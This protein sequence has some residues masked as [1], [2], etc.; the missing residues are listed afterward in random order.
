MARVEQRTPRRSEK[1]G[2]NRP[3]GRARGGQLREGPTARPQPAR[4]SSWRSRSSQIRRSIRPSPRTSLPTTSS[5]P[6]SRRWSQSSQAARNS[7]HVLPAGA[8]CQRG[9][10]PLISPRCAAAS[11][12]STTVR[13]RCR[14]PRLPIAATRRQSPP[15]GHVYPLRGT[16][17]DRMPG[18]S[19]GGAR[20]GSTAGRG[21]PSKRDPDSV[22]SLTSGSVLCEAP[23]MHAVLWS[24]AQA[25]A[26]APRAKEQ[27]THGARTCRQ[28]ILGAAW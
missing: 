6:R 13:P 16:S 4:R 24:L 28:W 2:A 3:G 12:D 14:L 27:V 8:G 11:A 18:G 5:G 20:P 10:G 19:S 23:H 21:A 22:T 1:A 17:V 25:P 15:K 26:S 9:A 7:S